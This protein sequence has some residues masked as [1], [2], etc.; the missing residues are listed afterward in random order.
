VY[1]V[2]QAGSS[3]PEVLIHPVQYPPIE[4]SA[5]GSHTEFELEAHT[6]KL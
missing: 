5:L 3:M 1:P 2:V 6:D 4:E